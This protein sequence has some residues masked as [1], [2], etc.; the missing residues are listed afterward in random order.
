MW[1]KPTGEERFA[2][3]GE[4]GRGHGERGPGR[5]QG[6]VQIFIKYINSPK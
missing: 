1:K 4:P 2:R 3:H 5:G 6:T